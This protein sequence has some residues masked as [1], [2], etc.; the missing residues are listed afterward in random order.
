MPHNSHTTLM[1][2]AL[3]SENGDFL[4]I[5]MDYFPTS[6]FS[7]LRQSSSIRV[8][9]QQIKIILYKFLCSIKFLH[10]ANVM[11]RDIK[12][13]NILINENLDVRICDFGYARSVLE[14]I[15]EEK[16]LNKL[17]KPRRR[18]TQHICTRC[19]RPPE[20]ILLEN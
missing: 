17:L 6:L 20:V 14:E 18:L 10:S 13:T 2:T 7:V 5:V 8:S 15:S 16:A 11:H 12:P 3:L 1:K 9:E 19:Y 4:F